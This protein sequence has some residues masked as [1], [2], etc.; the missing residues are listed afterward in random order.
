[1]EAGILG[2]LVGRSLLLLRNII[3]SR[4]GVRK[5]AKTITITTVVLRDL[6][7]MLSVVFIFVNIR[8]ILF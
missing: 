7:R 5:A 6:D 4:G 1:M 3:C 8:F 2:D